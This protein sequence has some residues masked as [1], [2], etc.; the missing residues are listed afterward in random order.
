MRLI[1]MRR[2]LFLFI[3]ATLLSQPLFAQVAP[4]APTTVQNA[5]K[6][7]AQTSPKSRSGSFI[8]LDE[9]V[10]V[11]RLFQQRTPKGGEVAI[12]RLSDEKYKAFK[13]N[14]KK[15]VNKTYANKIFLFPVNGVTAAGKPPSPKPG[16][17]MVVAMTHDGGC[18]AKYIAEMLPP[19][20]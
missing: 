20:R 6:P 5:P 11:L 3:A 18:F 10:E 13:Q 15:F 4:A 1:D 12:L 7:P 16:D 14:P 2:L 8:V 19:P 17:D 9:G